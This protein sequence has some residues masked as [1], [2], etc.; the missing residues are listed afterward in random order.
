MTGREAAPSVVSGSGARVCSSG[1]VRLLEP[2]P[3]A[4]GEGIFFQNR[5]KKITA[6][7]VQTIMSCQ[8]KWVYPSPVVMF[9]V[10]YRA[11]TN[12]KHHPE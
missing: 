1:G 7:F 3:S 10:A 8:M 9:S 6:Q 2:L 12:I 4:S 11:S 5:S